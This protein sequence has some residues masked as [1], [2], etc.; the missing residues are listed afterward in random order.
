MPQVAVKVAAFAGSLRSDSWNRKLLALAVRHAL[1]AGAEVDVIDL[2]ALAIPLYD[3]DTEHASGLPAGVKQ[4]KERIAAA[5]GV[6]VATPEY[7]HS[8]PGVLKNVLDWVSRPPNNPLRDKT[9]ALMGASTGMAGTLR[10]NYALRPV[11][12][13][14]GSWLV[15]GYVGIPN[16]AQAFDDAG[17]LKDELF[18]K[19]LEAHIKTFV[20]SIRD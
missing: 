5:Q 12:S 8:I 16:A 6:L 9:V 18:R 15:P 2:R 10:V 1:D 17:N 11:F 13:T 19:Q 4:L 14:A 7:N 3:A 20:G